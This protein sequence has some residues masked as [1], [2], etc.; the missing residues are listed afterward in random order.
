MACEAP[1]PI[2]PKAPSKTL[3]PQSKPRVRVIA[4]GLEQDVLA[5]L[6]P[7]LSPE[8]YRRAEAEAHLSPVITL[9]RTPEVASALE[10]MSDLIF[11][12]L[13]RPNRAWVVRPNA[14]RNRMAADTSNVDALLPG[15]SRASI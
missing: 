8:A 5:L 2:L 9:E 10:A 7:V 11:V 3:T 13:V 12:E 14:G 15:G 4:P 1:A 6:Q